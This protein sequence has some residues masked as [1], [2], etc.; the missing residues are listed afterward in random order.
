MIL[1]DQIAQSIIRQAGPFTMVGAQRLAKN[2]NAVEYVVKN[3]I[4]GDIVEVGVWRGGSA[5]AMILALK[6]LN[7][8]RLVHLY[9]TFDGMTTPTD[10]DV[11]L[12]GMYAGDLLSKNKWV[13]CEA[14]IDEVKHNISLCNYP[15]QLVNYHRGDILQNKFYPASIAVLRLDTDWYESTMFELENFYP[16]VSA[17]GVVMIDDYGHWRGCQ[18]A[19]DHFISGKRIELKRIDYSGVFWLKDNL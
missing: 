19:V 11:D 8:F 13:R 14:Q 2:I 3:R 15:S 4:V 9:D 1:S 16:F 7:E 18:K 6:E 12:N 17:G 10:Q 5:M